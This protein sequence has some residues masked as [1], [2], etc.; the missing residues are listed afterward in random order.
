[1]NR[2]DVIRLARRHASLS[3]PDSK[4]FDHDSLCHFASLVAAH[5][6]QRL[7]ADA[8]LLRGD[9][10]KEREA[11][12]ASSAAQSIRASSAE[13][14]LAAARAEEREACAAIAESYGPARPLVRQDCIQLIRGRWEGEQAASANIARLIRERGKP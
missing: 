2:D 9:A 8:A 10:A 7:Q 3:K 4:E 12:W 11:S 14:A 6:R 13:S 5:E 1:M